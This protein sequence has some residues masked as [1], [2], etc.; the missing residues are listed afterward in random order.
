MPPKTAEGDSLLLRVTTAAGAV[1]HESAIQLGTEQPAALPR[2]ASGAP[3]W[4]DDGNKIVIQGRGFAAVFD[5]AKGDFDAADP[6]HACAVLSFPT[7]HV[8]RYDFGDLNGPNSPPYAVFPGPASRSF[9]AARKHCRPR[10][11]VRRWLY[12]HSPPGA[13]RAPVLMPPR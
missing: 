13:F 11:A 6:R 10:R 4:S 2:P 9:E 12:G 8:T 7:I 5:R 1:V 3:R